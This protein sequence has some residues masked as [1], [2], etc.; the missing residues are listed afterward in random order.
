MPHRIVACDDE[1]HVTK[2]VSM[3]LSKA[4]LIVETA[5]DGVGAL[6]AI[7]R[8]LPSLLITDCQMPRMG[9]IELCRALRA[10]ERTSQLPVIML[11]AKGFEFDHEDMKRELG[12][13][14]IVLK[15]FSP[16]ELLQTVEKLLERGYAEHPAKS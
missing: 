11:T 8:E 14:E 16:R 5:Q 4:G 10:D 15:P 2:S 9:G 13:S 7:R 1:V 6:E 3:K 12:I